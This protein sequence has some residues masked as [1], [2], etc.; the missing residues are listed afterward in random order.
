M[1][2]AMLQ[3]VEQI[4]AGTYF[5]RAPDCAANYCGGLRLAMHKNG[6]VLWVPS[7]D[8]CVKHD[9]PFRGKDRVMNFEKINSRRHCIN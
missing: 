3:Q 5:H 1:V 9:R 8:S 7:I 6:S 4:E 2:G